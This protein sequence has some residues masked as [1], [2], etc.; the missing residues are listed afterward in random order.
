MLTKVG[1]GELDAGIVYATDVREGTGTSAIEVPAAV[2]V[3]AEY[4]IAVLRDA[5]RPDLAAAFVDFVL[6]PAGRSLLAEYGFTTP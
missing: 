1:A 6:S 5:P 2:N 4:P 3:V